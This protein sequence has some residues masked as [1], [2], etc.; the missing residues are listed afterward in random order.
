[1]DCEKNKNEQLKSALPDRVL[2]SPKWICFYEQKLFLFPW[3]K[4][5]CHCHGCVF[6]CKSKRSYSIDI[7]DCG[8]KI[9]FV[10]E[11]MI[12]DS[13]Q[14]NL[15]WRDFPFELKLTGLG[16]KKNLTEIDNFTKKKQTL[17][18]TGFLQRNPGH[19]Y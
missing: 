14:T 15:S 4:C 13:R 2:L 16:A 6:L 9:G 7:L 3:A 19:Q 8:R 5:T 12:P 10:T 18:F 17:Y 1:M 11:I